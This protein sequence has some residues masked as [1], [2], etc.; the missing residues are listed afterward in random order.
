MIAGRAWVSRD[1]QTLDARQATLKA[2]GQI[3][4]AVTHRSATV[5]PG[6][7]VT[8]NG[9]AITNQLVGAGI[10]FNNEGSIQSSLTPSNLLFGG[11]GVVTRGAASPGPLSAVRECH[12]EL[13]DGEHEQREE[14]QVD[15][16]ARSRRCI[17]APTA[18]SRGACAPARAG[19]VVGERLAPAGCWAGA[20]VRSPATHRM[21]DRIG[22]A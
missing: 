4:G 6:V 9:L 19:R 17:G 14:E 2:A 13:D 3:S 18:C 8:G 16:M 12:P 11:P 7:T 20:A 1:W 21:D 15:V 10:N 22:L 5:E